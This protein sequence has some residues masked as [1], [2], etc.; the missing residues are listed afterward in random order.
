M[1]TR[2]IGKLSPPVADATTGGSLWEPR[3]SSFSPG[4]GPKVIDE[5][6]AGVGRR[7]LVSKRAKKAQSD[8]DCDLDDWVSHV[9]GAGGRRVQRGRTRPG[10]RTAFEV[11][12]ATPARARWKQIEQLAAVTV[13]TPDGS[14]LDRPVTVTDVYRAE[15]LCR[16]VRGWTCW[17]ISRPAGWRLARCCD[18]PPR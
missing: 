10:C 7:P 15:V 16:R 11:E 14:A 12:L 5:R 3:R 6:I 4:C 17:S 13:R 8:F 18:V 9:V 1:E 2:C